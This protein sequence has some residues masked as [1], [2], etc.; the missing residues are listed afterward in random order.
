MPQTEQQKQGTASKKGPFSSEEASNLIMPVIQNI[1]GVNM[2]LQ[3]LACD[4]VALRLN[5]FES[6]YSKKL[7]ILDKRYQDKVNVFVNL[8]QLWSTPNSLLK[9]ENKR[10]QADSVILLADWN[11]MKPAVEKHFEE[12]FKMISMMQTA[13]NF[14]RSNQFNRLTIIIGTIAIIATLG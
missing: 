12:S 1:I 6:L 11:K 10:T 7:K 9:S 13:L 4:V 5:F 2:D 14:H 3:S 8:Y